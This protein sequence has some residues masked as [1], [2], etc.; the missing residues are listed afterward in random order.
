MTH[1]EIYRTMA[2]LAYEESVKNN[3]AHEPENCPYYNT[4]KTAEEGE[5]GNE[6]TDK[7]I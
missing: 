7:S 3:M 4:E 1:L 6:E 5:K 2:D